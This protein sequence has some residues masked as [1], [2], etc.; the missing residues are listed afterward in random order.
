MIEITNPDRIVYPQPGIT[1]GRVVEYYARAASKMLVHLAGRPLT[2]DRF[3][4]GIESGGFRQ[5]NAARSFP[6]FIGRYAVPKREGGTTTYPVV[7]DQQGLVYLAN[8]GT[9]V[10]HSWTGRLPDPFRP[11]RL[12]IDLDPPDENPSAARPAARALR[13][14]LGEIGMEA[15]L[16]TT[17]STG[18]HVVSSILPG[19]GIEEIGECAR[20]LAELAAGRDPDL[21]TTEW[22]IAN[23]TGRV[24]VDWLRNT[25][26]QTGVAPWS[27]RARP[28]APVATP[29]DWEELDDTPSD[30]WT[31]NDIEERLA[32][33]DP[34][35]AALERP[36]DPDR[37]L[38]AVREMAGRSGISLQPFDRFRN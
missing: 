29:I 33:P 22:R 18:Y 17:G 27:L 2:L 31:L 26:A 7:D 6:D 32:I 20:L 35:A 14:L 5:K 16:M 19:P 38:G 36:A 10:F 1:K 3:P 8:Q 4:R 12:V 13:D 15:R 37:I 24:F 9:V 21:L 34:L 28:A 30:R 11:D 25:Y 23:R